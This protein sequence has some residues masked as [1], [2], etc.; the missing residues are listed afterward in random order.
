MQM[1]AKKDLTKET[2]QEGK[3]LKEAMVKREG[4]ETD[5]FLDE[6]EGEKPR[7]MQMEAKKDLTTETMLDSEDVQKGCFPTRRLGLGSHEKGE[8]SGTKEIQ[9]STKRGRSISST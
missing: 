6:D 2:T 4:K 8:V 3:D 1:E 7:R 5:Y 9:A